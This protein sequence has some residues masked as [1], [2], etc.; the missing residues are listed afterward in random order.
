M[1][2][3]VK[4][5]FCKVSMFVL[6]SALIL[7][8]C[9]AGAL[10]G[11]TEISPEKEPAPIMAAESSSQVIDH[12]QGD[13]SSV[14]TNAA[15][16]QV[17]SQNTQ[18]SGA[19]V[20]TTG[21]G[22]TVGTYDTLTEACD[23]VNAANGSNFTIRINKDNSTYTT[24][25]IQSGKN[26]LLTSTSG[27]CFVIRVGKKGFRH[28]QVLGTVLMENIVMD[29]GIAGGSLDRGGVEVLSGGSLTLAG[30]STIKNCGGFTSYTGL[31]GTFG[32][33]VFAEAATVVLDGGILED[34]MSQHGGAGI[35]AHSG[36]TVILNSG[37]IRNNRLSWNGG[38]GGVGVALQ[39]GSSFTMNGGTI[40]GNRTNNTDA[41]GKG[42][43]VTLRKGST[44]VMKGGAIT[45]NYCSYS[46]GGIVVMDA[47]S[48]F[49]MY[50]GEITDNKCLDPDFDSQDPSIGLNGFGGGVY[51]S[52]YATFTM[53]GGT[54]SG[55]E[56]SA[57]GGGICM[58]G[59][60]GHD[61]TF[62]MK[63]GNIDNNISNYAGGGVFLLGSYDGKLYADLQGGSISGNK[64]LS[65]HFIDIDKT[66]GGYGGGVYTYL[67][68][69]TTG[70][71]VAIENNE[72][73]IQGGG[74]YAHTS[75]V[76]IAGDTKIQ[77]NTAGI[78]GGG[79]W[80][81]TLDSNVLTIEDTVSVSKNTA[82]SIGGGI[83]VNGNFNASLTNTKIA[84]NKARYGAGIM[85]EGK[86]GA[87]LDL[88]SVKVTGNEATGTHG[89]G[90]YLIG[91]LSATI[92][93]S[94]I[95]GNTA[96]VNGGGIYIASVNKDV[97]ATLSDAT[98]LKNN[99]AGLEGGAVYTQSF[100][101]YILG[102]EPG[103]YTAVKSGD[104]S[105][106]ISAADTVFSGNRAD[107]ACQPPTDADTVFANIAYASTSLLAN[108]DYLNPINNYD[109]NY[110][111]VPPLTVYCVNYDANG[112]EGSHQDG[113]LFAES[114]YPVK[115]LLDTGI[116]REGY[117]FTGW[118]TA[119][120]GSGDGYS[121][122][123]TITITGDVTLYAQW[124][125]EEPPTESGDNSLNAIWVALCV[126]SL[127]GIRLV[128]VKRRRSSG[129]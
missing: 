125:P 111:S 74:I 72:A 99:T 57:Y 117:I 92:R 14:G 95:S 101:G 66:S 114:L 110:R 97:T 58:D 48:S 23:A 77:S 38:T 49:T 67:G 52:A 87:V 46:G 113:G 68:N 60:F 29:G 22:A 50:D 81:Y 79:V 51:L 55:N 44:G 115:S 3:L 4:K 8:P 17:D 93:G 73:G 61:A 120:D 118:N 62:I 80:F 64:A 13:N 26:V 9:S 104:Y 30:G 32:G 54:I 75:S 70:G 119:A 107:S 65:H 40:S 126:L 18:A 127:L 43:G 7:A 20:V 103:D 69:V 36:S 123:D 98:V 15:T 11:N 128:V 82:G 83:L 85:A 28:L 53:I 105:N 129:Y 39:N 2:S 35:F 78:S 109:I 122:D 45:G 84:N 100:T 5:L 24:A 56:V 71:S 34:N 42:G 89:G 116:T 37:E 16:D 88:Q 76:K 33:A 6:I 19:Y 10:A 90:M 1:L 108:S 47:G 31:G 41:N 124:T 106:L 27:N 25:V 121:A 63:G 21:T 94:E 112:G 91:K 59:R 102:T 86:N 96:K 12:R